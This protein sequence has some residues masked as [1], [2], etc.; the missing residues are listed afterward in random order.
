MITTVKRKR[1]GLI[2]KLKD[3]AYISRY[4]V[5]HDKYKEG[6][7]NGGRDAP[8]YLEKHFDIVPE[9]SW[10]DEEMERMKN[11]KEEYFNSVGISAERQGRTTTIHKTLGLRPDV[12]RGKRPSDLITYHE[13][14]G[15]FPK[16]EIISQNP[17][18]EIYLG[19][20]GYQEWE[21]MWE[22]MFYEPQ[23]KLLLIC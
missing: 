22:K 11:L 1:N 23:R 19:T 14:A 5:G 18:A 6:E 8:A 21:N 13:E 12:C 17:C 16:I 4:N 15:P 2:F 7:F 9:M 20:A 10:I 3:G